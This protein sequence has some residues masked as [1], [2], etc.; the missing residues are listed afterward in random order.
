M[1]VC[2]LIKRFMA[3]LRSSKVLWMRSRSRERGAIV[4]LDKFCARSV[5]VETFLY[6][7]LRF[8]AREI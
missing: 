8:R 1:Y 3:K 5:I 4:L 7:F 2:S 6:L